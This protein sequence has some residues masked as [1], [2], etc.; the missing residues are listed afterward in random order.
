MAAAVLAGINPVHGL[1]ASA[2]G[3][4]SGG[5]SSSTRLMVITTTSAAA[6]AAG[7]ALQSVPAEDRPEAMLLLTFISGVLMIVAALLRL[8]RYVRFVSHSVMAGFLAGVAV[9]IV[10]GQIPDLLGAD[11]SG[12]FAVTKALSVVLH[13]ST[14]TAAS[15]LVGL[16]ALAI[17][18]LLARTRFSLFASLVALAI[19]TAIVMVAGLDGVALVSDVGTIPHGLPPFALPHLSLLSPAL[20]SGAL[21]V[22]AIVLVQGVGV[23]QSVP[24]RDGTRSR[25]GTDFTAQGL[26]NL[27][28]GLFGGQPVGGSV[29]Q[30]SLNVAAGARSRWGS[31]FTGL[32][33]LL[34]LGA[35]SRVVGQVAMPTL[36]A[37]LVLAGIGSIDPKNLRAVLSTGRTSRIAVISTFIATLL[38]PVAVAVAVGV[39]ISLLLQLNQDA[40]DLKVVRLE[41]VGDGHFRETSPPSQLTDDDIVVLDVYGSLFYAGAHTL[42]RR[43]PD[44]ASARRATV[45]VRLRGRG[46]LGATFLNVIGAYAAALAAHEGRLCLTGLDPQVVAH[47]AGRQVP[48]LAPGIRLYPATDVVGESTYAA[49]LDAESQLVESVEYTDHPA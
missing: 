35:F 44:I 36:A 22:T 49:L 39:A 42:A 29:G 9:N 38:L 16:A 7:S 32:W 37:V 26:S 27:A 14:V 25:T 15:A 1:Y 46:S 2:V 48:L 23:A 4:I 31:V 34:I 3:P 41:S 28:S 8:G 40:V 11:S 10:C 21:S 6:L 12:D 47:W 45:V 43:L 5:L 19:P 33:M 20:I 18:L 17:L 30:T 13:P 24:N